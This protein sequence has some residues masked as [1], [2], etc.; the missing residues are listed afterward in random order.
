MVSTDS[1][2]TGQLGRTRNLSL[3]GVI[4]QS[5]GFLG[6]VFS[7]A[8]LLPSVAGLGFSGKGAGIA[9][10]IALIIATVGIGGVAWIASRYAKRIH[11]AGAIYEYVND[12][13]GRPAGFV[14]G[15]IYYGGMILLTI[16]IFPALGGFLHETLLARTG[17]DVPWLALALIAIAV[18]FGMVIYGVEVSMKVQL[19]IAAVSIAAVFG[20][21]LYVIV[22]GGAAGNSLD[23]F[24]PAKAAVPGE[25]GHSAFS[26]IL[27][28]LVY[29][30]LC[31]TG[32]ETAANLAE[33][34]ADPGRPIPKAMLGCV[35]GVGIFYVAVMYAMTSAFGFDLGQFL[36]SFPQLLAAAGT[37][38]VGG[39]FFAKLVDRIIILDILGVAT[40]C[41]RGIF[42]MARDRHLPAP[43]A[44]V[45]PGRRTPW[46]AALAL[47]ALCAVV[48]VWAQ[49]ADGIVAPALGPDGTVA[50]PGAWFRIFQYG[51]TFG[52]LGLIIVYLM[53]ALSGFEHT[54]EGRTGQVVAAIL[55]TG[56][57]GAAIFGTV[58]KAPPAFNLDSVWW[59]MVIWIVIG[60]ADDYSWALVGE[61][62]GRYLWIL[63][64]TPQITAELRADLLA[65]LQAQGYNTN[66]L[67]WTPQPPA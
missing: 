67:T 39:S 50:D 37:P 22:K 11:H 28:G 43:L 7:A 12:G 55:G 40:S 63:A 14:A 42:A 38:G 33:E 34:T 15:W 17:L 13:W 29:A 8:F 51:A 18:V 9:S 21:A 53:V 25:G 64:R 2:P 30:C 35:A 62:S 4:A 19:T 23:P 32:F 48:A 20:F 46:I 47:G 60:L 27:F 66:A 56:A 65:K 45:H 16:A 57:T 61:P 52:A 58:Y 36:S 10:P 31:F 6:P 54:G 5:I 49:L 3:A 1:P 26:G 59:V 24:N 41:S 44:G